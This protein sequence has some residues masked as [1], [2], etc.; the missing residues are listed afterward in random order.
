MAGALA[1]AIARHKIP[2]NPAAVKRAGRRRDKIFMG[3]FKT[4]NGLDNEG[5]NLVRQSPFQIATHIRQREFL[6]QE[7]IKQKTGRKVIKMRKSDLA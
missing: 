7:R 4:I 1:G 5:A 2:T 3:D 6:I